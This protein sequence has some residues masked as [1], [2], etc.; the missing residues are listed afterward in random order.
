M[1]IKRLLAAFF[2]AAVILSFASISA[3]ADSTGWRE[4]SGGWRYYTTE[5]SYVKHEWKSIDGHR[6][7][8]SSRYCLPKQI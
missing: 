2:G 6:F 4:E 5:K 3:L 8:L 1:A 7:L